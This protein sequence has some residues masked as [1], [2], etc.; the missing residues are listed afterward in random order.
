M[1]HATAAKYAFFSST[2]ETF[3][4]ID[5]M[6]NHKASFRKFKK[7]EILS[8]Q[9]C[10]LLPWQFYIILKV[11]A[12]AIRQEKKKPINLERNKYNYLFCRWQ[13]YMWKVLDS[14]KRLLEL[15]NEFSNCRIQNQ[16]LNLSCISLF[17]KETFWKKQLRKWR[18]QSHV[19][20]YRN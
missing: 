3:I 4:S 14:T 15:K 19:K 8:R 5:H 12:R 13:S 2:R 16:H 1:F 11:L 10:P 7:T 18:K 17:Y 9:G 6:V 20:Y